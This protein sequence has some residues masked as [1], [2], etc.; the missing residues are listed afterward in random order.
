VHSSDRLQSPGVQ[1]C[2]IY[3]SA[4]ESTPYAIYGQLN[5]PS[6]TS[7]R[8]P[9]SPLRAQTSEL[10]AC[11]QNER[12]PG[13]R[14]DE[15]STHVH[16]IQLPLHTLAVLPRGHACIRCK[17]L[18]LA[19][20]VVLC[21]KT[22]SDTYPIQCRNAMALSHPVALVSNFVNGQSVNTKL[23]WVSRR[24]SSLPGVQTPCT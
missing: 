24:S 9:P 19:S 13:H 3:P 21:K 15:V 2:H 1:R 5:W 16:L 10:Y 22:V 12:E 14:P 18:K 8:L 23:G 11:E 4:D 17:R 7:L 6:G 20:D